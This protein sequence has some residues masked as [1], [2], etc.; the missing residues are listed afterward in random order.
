MIK[1]KTVFTVT[2]EANPSQDVIIIAEE[3]ADNPELRYFKSA[4][5]LRSVILHIFRDEIFN[6]DPKPEINWQAFID[7][8]YDFNNRWAARKYKEAGIDPTQNERNQ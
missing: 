7:Y 2:D 1:I 6:T 3:F 8:M 4:L 5:N